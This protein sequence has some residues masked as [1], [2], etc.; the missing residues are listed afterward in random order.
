MSEESSKIDFNKFFEI[1]REQNGISLLWQKVLQMLF[2][3]EP[4]ISDDC[5]KIFCIYFSLLDDGNTCI[6]LNKD[7]LIKKWMYKYQGLLL[8][9][10]LES[11]LEQSDFEKVI[12]NSIPQILQNKCSHLVKNLENSGTSIQ[13]VETPFVIKT[14]NGE[15]YLFATKYYDAKISI[16]ERVKKLFTGLKK[17]DS[18]EK[19]KAEIISFFEKNTW[20]KKQNK[21]IKLN[22]E[23][24][25]A[26]LSG[27][28]S[29]LILTGGPGTGK[30]TAICFL[31]WELMKKKDEDGISYCDYNLHLA[32]P[33][34]KAADRMKESVSGSLNAFK[35]EILDENPRIYQ[36]LT[37]TDSTTIHRLLSYNP[38]KND[39]NFNRDNQFD[40]KSIFIIDE[41]SM[42]DI[43]LFKCLLEAIPDEA[44]LFILGDKDQLPS[45]GAGAVLGDLLDK[46]RDNVVEL[47]ETN[48]FE[49]DSEVSR[50]KD[51]LMTDEDFPTDTDT[52]GKWFSD[53]SMFEFKRG[54]EVKGNPVYY[55]SLK[56]PD[57]NSKSEQKTEK[58]SE[59]IRTLVK[60]W[61]K[62]FCEDLSKE[63]SLPSK[64][65]LN[66]DS[67]KKLWDLSNEAKI[68]CAERESIRGVHKI[69][70][71]ISSEVCSSNKQENKQPAK[72][73]ENGY[74]TG[75]LLILTKNQKMFRLYNGDC[76]IVVSFEN[77]DVKYLMLE[78]KSAV[79][80]EN[81]NLLED[82]KSTIFR[83]GSFMFYPLYLLPKDSIETAYAIT[84]HKSQGS[85][86]KNIMIF[87]PE[88]NGHPLLNRQIIYTA[89]TRTEGNTYVIASV[90][91]LNYAKKTVVQR[92]TMIELV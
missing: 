43:H 38:E 85:G 19:E 58:K 14:I 31:L 54:D 17:T 56:E 32:A 68:L 33:S 59:Q 80:D 29:N 51:E 49:K 39:F 89:V 74:F 48:R 11:K 67:L 20:N 52:F 1:L 47:I 42:I 25:D 21:S 72:M 62:V 70:E 6:A 79:E 40:K 69:N 3:L 9:S 41:A 37:L 75:Q 90:D 71:I 84:I 24:A 30:T 4:G 86:Y 78:K 22:N 44:R 16:E 82:S 15:Y 83:C 63:A 73:D 26:I 64:K 12:E 27:Q 50:L 18:Y 2:E 66:E 35:Q 91:S 23:Q 34:G 61:S 60:K 53:I 8:V 10:G 57:K 65:D 46:K 5:M 87:L 76:G 13:E 28:S 36:R 77:D 81:T 55:Y 88:Q 45:V 92:D 7:Q